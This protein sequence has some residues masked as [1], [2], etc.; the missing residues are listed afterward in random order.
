MSDPAANG[1]DADIDPLDRL[2]QE[3]LRR[4]RAGEAVTA[5]AFAAEYPE[6]AAM[7]RDLLP[8]L[9][10]L[11]T[12]KRE[13]QTSTGGEGRP[14]LPQLDRLGDFRIVRELGRGGMGVVFEAV[15]EALDRRVALKVM[16]QASL[17]SER[18]LSRFRREAHIAAQLHHSN[19]VPVF[20]SGESDGF[21]WYAMQFIGGQSLDRWREGEAKAPPVGSGAWRNRARFIAR[22]GADAA[23]ALHHAHSHG[24]LHRDI[25]PANLLLDQ[26]GRVWV[27]DFGLAKALEEEGL[28]HSGDLLGTLQYMAPEQF[29]GNYDVRSEVYALGIT[30]YELLALRPAYSAKTRSE[31]LERIR[32][33]A[34][35]DLR[36][37]C[38]DL[39]ED[40]A[41]VIECAIARE[42][43]DR[44]RDAAALAK[45][46]QAF[47]EDRPIAARRQSAIGLLLRWC[48]RNRL[49]ASLA[50]A[51]FVA[52]LGGAITA[53]TLYVM[54]DDALGEAKE[55]ATRA[56]QQSDR[57][58][59]N[60]RLALSAFTEL[61]DGLVGRDRMLAFEE[62]P[63]T[64][65]AIVLTP[66]VRPQNVALLENILRF[67]DAFASQNEGSQ[68]LQLETARAYR[69]VGAIQARFGKLDE[70]AAAYEQSLAR[71]Q[72]V[73]ERDVRR[74]IAAALVDCG[75][76]EQRRGHM[77]E[78]G[79]SF[80]RALQLLD[81]DKLGD[82]KVVRFE[83]AEVHF[84]LARA[85]EFRRRGPPP[86]GPGGPGG[87]GGGSAMR[88]ELREMMVAARQHLDTA[89]DLV[90]VLLEEDTGNPEFRALQA[91]ILCFGG[92]AAIRGVGAGAG[93]ARD[94]EQRVRDLGA[95]LEIF[96]DLVQRFPEN[97]DFRLELC[98]E[99]APEARRMLFGRARSEP[100]AE[101]TVVFERLREAKTHADVLLSKQPDYVEYRSLRARIGAALGFMLR[102]RSS[103]EEGAQREATRREAIAELQIVVALDPPSA[104][105]VDEARR[106]P[107]L[108][109]Q[110][111]QLRMQLAMLLN[112]V[113]ETAGSIT[114]TTSVLDAI[115]A[116]LAAA[117]GAPA[118]T[119]PRLVD[120]VRRLV[121]RLAVAELQQR[122][123]AVE[124]RMPSAE[125]GPD[126]PRRR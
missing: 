32:T 122:L 48:R 96:R 87:P 97:E 104:T 123:R 69:R 119:D 31:L 23:Q 50:A 44:Y 7:L 18:Q 95:G 115:E 98:K 25:K 82:G 8:T 83:R 125:R 102:Q 3:F 108:W 100:V 61:F 26:E 90:K 109:G 30:L 17:L 19:I 114:I 124:A 5:E 51:T 35:T 52:V 91:R 37:L 67:Y 121:D 74:E 41:M 27:T 72:F 99:L 68:S 94:T 118:G 116:D 9:L 36:R 107:R 112:E 80:R 6:H 84:L 14:V 63:D 57:A 59:V 10:A 89:R 43:A 58:E 113:G 120:T 11:E 46:L 79:Q 4:H 64:G 21:H 49:V 71:Y 105:S 20:G 85:V 2:S 13:R 88:T 110:S 55:S 78:A 47:L 73:T 103:G 65:E 60:L 24:M 39:P 75:Q 126:R 1:G 70:A 92:P 16:P 53:S 29:S 34:P 38:P 117:G 28:T 62:D 42:P 40:L 101:N 54:T 76:L 33:Q 86:D 106:D 45:D 12:A 15:Q 81:A 93:E 22:L 66:S 111:M 77:S 56:Q